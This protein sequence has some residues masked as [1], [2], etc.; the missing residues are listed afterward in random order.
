MLVVGSNGEIVT[1]NTWEWIALPVYIFVILV[2][3]YF[4][5]RRKIKDNSIYKYYTWGL[6]VKI[7]GGISF[8]LI[9]YYYYEGGDSTDYFA[10]SVNMYKLLLESPLSWL[11]IEFGSISDA[12]YSLFTAT[13]GAP[14]RGL[15]FDYQSVTLLRII[16][17]LLVPG[18][19]SYVL[20]TIVLLWIAYSG[21]WKLYIVFTDYYPTMKGR[22]AIAILFFPSVIFWGSGI[23]KDTITLSFS[24][25]VVYCI[26]MVFIVRRSQ[27]RYTV[28]LL[29]TM[30]CV[31]L[32]KPYIIVA[33]LPGTFVWVFFEKIA[34]I[35]NV[36]VK[37]LIVPFIVITCG[38]GAYLFFSSLGGYMGKFALNNISTTLTVTSS[39][40]KQD[41][42]NG[43]AFDI[44]DVNN[45][46][47][48]Y[49][50]KAPAA[51]TAGLYRPFIW[52]AG[53]IVMIL[54]GIENLL[55]LG[56]SIVMLL[57]IG[58]VKLIRRLF[59]EPLLFFAFSYSIF[60][61]FA[62][63]LSTSNFGA[64]VRFK[65]A[66]LPF[67][68]STLFILATKNQEVEE[69]EEEYLID[70]ELEEGN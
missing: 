31:L 23:M 10:S 4:H 33:L 44:G 58:P 62:V 16:N 26:Y 63:G 38:G 60:F 54:S 66:Y 18:F 37:I 25:W 5:Q 41:Y 36:L 17:P 68:V 1:I 59:K 21:I 11:H 52:E 56:L 49:F 2:V 70:N 40:L 15:F 51:I 30:F 8:V 22:L 61:A 45:T 3:S 55:L 27:F 14:W 57:R 13:S 48:G 34:K 43:H 53:N 19:S 67:F 9:Y 29:F 20:T 24:G 32:I 42:Y 47:T 35:K 65:I 39:D 64:L 6:L 12:N 50:S 7:F 28:I 69:E 46:P